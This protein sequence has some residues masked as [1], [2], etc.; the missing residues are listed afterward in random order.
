KLHGGASFN[1]ANRSMGFGNY[2]PEL[3]AQLLASVPAVALAANPNIVPGADILT[4]YD[5]GAWLAGPV[6]RD[7]IWFSLSAHAPRL[8]QYLVG[9]YNPDGSQVLDDNLTWT[10]SAKV[11][12]QMTK[13]AQLSYFNNLQYKLIGHR[14][15]GGTFAESR[16]RN[17]NDKYPDVH[18]V[19]FTS[20]LG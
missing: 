17:L 12:W 9:N 16:A 1:G 7:K 14:N 18:Q 20:T 2:S 19:K 4:I 11:A 15:G 5:T 13:S 6:V 3:R 10:T 8:D